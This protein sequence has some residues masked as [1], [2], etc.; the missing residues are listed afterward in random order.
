LRWR[1]IRVEVGPE[2]SSFAGLLAWS[3]ERLSS[4]LINL[5]TTMFWVGDDADMPD[6]AVLLS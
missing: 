3:H 6:G 2:F 4:I 5:G 1:E